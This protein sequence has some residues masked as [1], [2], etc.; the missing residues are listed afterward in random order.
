MTAEPAVRQVAVAFVPF[1]SA[2]PYQRELAKHLRPF[3]VTVEVEISLK[4][5]AKRAWSASRVAEV[6][7][8]H[9]LPRVQLGLLGPLRAL[10]FLLRVLLLRATGRKIVWTV[11]NL[12]SHEVVNRRL[13]RWVAMCLIHLVSKVIVH[14]ETAVQ[15][16]ADEFCVE[17]HDKIVVIP[18]G[19]YVESYENVVGRHLARARLGLAEDSFV[20]LFLGNIRPYKGVRELIAAFRQMNAPSSVLVLAGRMLDEA[21][22]R[23]IERARDGDPRIRIDAGF[24]ADQDVQLYMN[25]CDVVVFPYLDVLTSGAV[26]LAMSFARPCVATETGCIPDVLDARGAFLYNPERADPLRSA[27]EHAYASRHR[28]PEMGAHNLTR[29]RQWGW[30]R[31]AHETADVYAQ[32]VGS[33][34]RNAARPVSDELA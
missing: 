3:G 32:A 14:S 28:L 26:I 16:V 20:Y 7:H 24:V 1:D 19:N 11:H 34:Q 17:R 8:L 12:Y 30:N 2:N 22:Q 31:V 9:W 21:A 15:L 23:D 10:I 25:A 29:A 13:E 5:L 6:V 27:L 4:D 18:H 33:R